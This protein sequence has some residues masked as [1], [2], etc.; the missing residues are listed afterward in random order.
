MKR[1]AL[2]LLCL[3]L[4]ASAQALDPVKLQEGLVSAPLA[5]VCVVLLVVCGYLFRELRAS[6]RARFDDHERHRSQL[7]E[8]LTTTVTLQHQLR[9]GFELLDKAVDRLTRS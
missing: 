3:A 2:T 4:P 1:A 5:T 6:E 7:V 9:E 8:V